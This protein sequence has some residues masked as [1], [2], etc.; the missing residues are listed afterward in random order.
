MPCRPFGAVMSMPLGLLLDDGA[1]LAQRLEVE[2][3]R[4]AADVA[5][6][7][8]G[9]ERVAE[10]VQQRPAEQDR[11]P[12]GA[13]VHVDL[14]G[15]G[16]STLVGS[17]TSSPAS[18]PSV[19]RTPCSPSSPRTI[20]TSR[21]AGTS[22]SRLGRVAEQRGDH[23]LRDQVLGAAHPD[24]ARAAGCRRARRGRRRST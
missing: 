8:V 16:A 13:G 15:A 12:A 9:D 24:L 19:T 4:A 2:V 17:K 18:S 20:S 6:A 14:V 10:P 11:D 22:Y 21:M 3:D 1:E 5:A 23:R 7:E